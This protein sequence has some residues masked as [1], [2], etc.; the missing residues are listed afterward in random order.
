MKR[1]P[2]SIDNEKIAPQGASTH[3]LNTHAVPK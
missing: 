2:F 1:W 3:N